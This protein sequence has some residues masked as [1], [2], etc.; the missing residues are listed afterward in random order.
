MNPNSQ[1]NGNGLKEFRR[2]LITSLLIRRPNIT[3]RQILATLAKQVINPKSG[4]PYALGTINKDLRIIREGWQ[5][6]AERNYGIWVAE[7]VATLEEV[8]KEGWA[9]G[10][11]NI[12]LKALA[13]KAKLKGLDAP[14]KMDLRINELDAAIEQELAKLAAT[15]ES[16]TSGAVAPEDGQH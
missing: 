1:G 4:K 9:T 12:V 5:E 7:M 13:Q 10:D 11:S 8:E 16:A 2:Q 15:G 14:T 6:K 3:Q